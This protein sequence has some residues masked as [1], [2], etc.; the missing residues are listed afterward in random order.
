MNTKLGSVLTGGASL[1]LALGLGSCSR[2]YTVGYV[3]AVS[4]S[5]ATISAYGIDYQTGILNQISGSP[6]AAT[7]SDP[8][9]IVAAPNSQAIYVIGGPVGSEGNAVEEVLVG[10]DGKLYG[11]HTYNLTGTYPTAAAVDSTGTFLYV[12]FTYQ[13]GFTPASPGPGGVSIFPINS[14][15]SLGTPITLNVGSNPVGIAVAPPVCVSTPLVSGNG[16]CTTPTGGSGSYNVYAYVVDQETALGKP[17]VLG[18]AQNMSTGALTPLSQNTSTGGV[19]QGVSA[20]VVPS[21]IAVDGTASFVYVTD[22]V[23]NQIYGYTISRSTT[24]NLTPMPSS[25]FATGAFPV[26]ITVDPRALF[27]YTANANAATVGSFAINQ[28]TGSL[29]AVA[30]SNFTAQAGTSCVTIDPNLG[31]YL[32]ASNYV[33]GNISGAE[34]NG[35]TGALSAVVNTPFPTSALPSCLV[36]VGNGPHAVSVN[37]PTTGTNP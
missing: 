17:T 29:S 19:L 3:Y 1:A 10:S 35:H 22:Q 16:T 24:G 34:L 13:N 27:V 31:T 28:A 36:A 20:G 21:A 32:Y 6:F 26:A 5:N 11:S 4:A 23:S 37:F 30:A 14:D 15:N 9:K 33:A 12:T 2:D 7:V 25:P 8:I 18:Y